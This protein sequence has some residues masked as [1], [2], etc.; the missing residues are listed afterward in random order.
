MQGFFSRLDTNGDGAIDSDEL[1][2]MAERARQRSSSSSE[3]YG[4]PIVYGIAVADGT[5]YVRTGTRMY[6]L[7]TDSKQ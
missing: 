7:R 2:A 6:C 4:D 5:F 1:K 3:S